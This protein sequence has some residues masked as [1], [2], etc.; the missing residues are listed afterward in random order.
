M[1]LISAA[2]IQGAVDDA[3]KAV[4]K[5]E[6]IRKYELLAGDFTIENGYLTPSMKVKRSE[7][8]R[9]FAADVERLYAPAADRQ[10]AAT[11]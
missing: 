5:A 10:P 1:T 9:D 4:S 2:V 11:R 6:S 7:V 8:L 3:N